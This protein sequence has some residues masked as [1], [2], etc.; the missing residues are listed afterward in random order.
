MMKLVRGAGK[1]ATGKKKRKDKWI[2]EILIVR[3]NGNE[4]KID[5]EDFEFVSSS[6]FIHTVM[7]GTLWSVVLLI[8]SLFIPGFFWLFAFLLSAV[9]LSIY[10]SKNK[11]S[12]TKAFWVSLMYSIYFIVAVVLLL[13]VSEILSILKMVATFWE[14]FLWVVGAFLIVSCT[15]GLIGWFLV[16]RYLY[17]KSS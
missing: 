6:A 12:F 3:W 8:L 15:S 17:G 16:T 7:L 13:F 14:F 9:P 5:W 11:C 2:L 1:T 10:F 4:M